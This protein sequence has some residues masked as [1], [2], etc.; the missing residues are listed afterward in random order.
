MDLATDLAGR[1][2]F[3]PRHRTPRW[4]A[5]RRTLPLERE[6]R[7]LRACGPTSSACLTGAAAPERLSALRFPLLLREQTQT[8][9]AMT[10]REKNNACADLRTT[11]GRRWLH[12]N[13]LPEFQESLARTSAKSFAI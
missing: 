8:S 5:E 4:S 13:E 2:C 3:S 9:E 12:E 10:P 6:A 1:R 11:I 7:R